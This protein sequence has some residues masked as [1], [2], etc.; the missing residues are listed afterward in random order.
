MLKS[1]G[2]PMTVAEMKGDAAVCLWMGGEGDLFRETFP[3]AVL[4]LVDSEEEDEEE[5]DDEEEEEDDE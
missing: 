1:G 5:E 2:L 3:I 4:D